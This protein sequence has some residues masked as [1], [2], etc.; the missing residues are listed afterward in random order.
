MRALIIDPALHSMGGHHYNAAVALKTK[1]GALG[2]DHDCL[3]SAYADEQAV[4]ELGC[5]PCFTR[6]VYGRSY[7]TPEE[8]ERQVRTTLAELSSALQRRPKADLLILPCCDQVLAFA[9]ARY[10]R[11]RRP[12]HLLLWAL[13]APH[14]NK[15]LDD[16]ST[17]S[18]RG[19]TRE[20]FAAL[21]RVVGLQRISAFCE[22]AEMADFYRDVASLDAR[23]APGPGLVSGRRAGEHDGDRRGP[24]VVG[25]IGFANEAKGYRLLPEAV[26]DVLGDDPTVRFMI[27]GIFQGSD[28]PDQGAVFEALTALGSRVAVS[29]EILSQAAYLDWLS[30]I[31]LVLLPYD[32]AV[33]RTRGSGVFFEARRLGIPVLATKGCGFARAAFDDGSGA[34]IT[35]RSSAGLA[36]AIRHGLRNLDDM[37]RRAGAAARSGNEIDGILDAVVRTIFSGRGRRARSDR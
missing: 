31:D 20:A 17:L 6:S 15:A 2:I 18:L 16:P 13:Y 21:Q 4:R 35:P 12:P 27:H 11:F 29:T 3:A 36:D 8:F 7:D 1:L 24:P 37:T 14:H 25:C 26:R 22:T 30:R 33:Y 19:E 28:A 9:L 23:A 34:E 5:T 10:L 32:P